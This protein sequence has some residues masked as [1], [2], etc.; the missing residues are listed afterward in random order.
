MTMRASSAPII[1]GLLFRLA[2]ADFQSVAD[3]VFVKQ[4]GG[5]NY[6][7]TKIVA[8]QLTG[9]ATVI[10]AGGVYTAAA[11]AG[12]Q[13]VSV[14]QSWIG[15]SGALTLVDATIAAIVAPRS[16][17]PILSLTTGSTAPVTGRVL[18]FGY[19]ID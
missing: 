15:L 12:T 6:V 2:N 17:I 5:T 4:F 11:K 8:T 19:S 3:Q 7:V 13:I 14:A 9:G 1:N 10:C 18:I 16:E